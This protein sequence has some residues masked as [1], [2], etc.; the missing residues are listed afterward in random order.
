MKTAAV[1]KAFS[2]LRIIIKLNK[3]VFSVSN[4]LSL[5]FDAVS[6]LF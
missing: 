4:C 1:S 5:C 2:I 6:S 3:F